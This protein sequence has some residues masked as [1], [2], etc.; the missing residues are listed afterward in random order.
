MPGAGV[1]GWGG[2][3]WSAGSEEEEPRVCPR[4]GDE[5]RRQG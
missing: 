1:G 5:L 4:A 2:G 3:E